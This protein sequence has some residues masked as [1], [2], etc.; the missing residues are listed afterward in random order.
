MDK[1]EK[2]DFFSKITNV[3]Y[4][5]DYSS[6]DRI[7][8]PFFIWTENTRNKIKKYFKKM[9][10]GYEEFDLYIHFPYCEEKC[11]FCRHCSCVVE[12][13]TQFDDYL[14]YL[15]K[16]INLYSQLFKKPKIGHI[17]LGGGT[18]TLFNLEKVINKLREKFKLLPSH[19]LNVESTFSCLNEE[20]IKTLKEIGVERLVLGVQSFDR[21][22]LEKINRTQD[23]KYFEEIYRI[24]RRI[25]IKSI[26][27]EL[28]G[29]LPGQSYKSFMSDLDYLID[30]GLDSVHIYSY[31]QTPKT[32]LG[33]K[34]EFKVDN[35]LK[36]RMIRDGEKLLEKA[37]YR[38]YGDDYSRK[39][40]HRNQ[41]I[42]RAGRIGVGKISLGVSAVGFVPSRKGTMIVY[43]NNYSIEN[44]KNMLDK[45]KFPVMKY[46]YL[47][48]EESWRAFII[49]H[50]RMLDLNLFDEDFEKILYSK[51]KE[52]FNDLLSVCR[53][54]KKNNKLI[55]KDWLVNSKFFY[56]PK[57]LNQCKK[58]IEKKY[59]E[60]SKTRNF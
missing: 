30:L 33:K 44:Y 5:T 46:Y 43:L 35:E 4:S 41:S 3:H 1:Q 13:K 38:Y 40:E 52:E 21:Q 39:A 23:K 26:N 18:P 60:Q 8:P 34:G 59:N 28:M 17:Y 48:E 10:K 29:G 6:I 50:L 45:N 56:S 14:K 51:F 36:T 16:E 11:W 19:Q 58:I 25:G 7:Y 9:K 42:Y 32:V 55:V 31:M 22:V 49:N 2:L 24:T 27:A 53:V 57:V 37:G 15:D 12:D 47:N 20:K 54:D